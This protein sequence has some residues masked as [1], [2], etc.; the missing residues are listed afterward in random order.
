[1]PNLKSSIKSVR[2]IKSKTLIN[3][4]RK[5]KL[6]FAAKKINQLINNKKKKE[7]IVYLPEYSS[8]MMKVA[9]TGVISKRNVSRKISRIT[10]K[11]SSI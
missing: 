2:K 3:R 5:S 8:Q 7:A 1:M 6:R 11:I 9:K 4:L 10:K